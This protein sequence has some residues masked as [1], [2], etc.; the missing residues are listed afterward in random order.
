[1]RAEIEQTPHLLEP[2]PEDDIATHNQSAHRYLAG[3]EGRAAESETAS[4]VGFV[5]GVLMFQHTGALRQLGAF[6]QILRFAQDD[7]LEG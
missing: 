2:F 6:P 3:L 7:P 5:Q 1:M 4:H